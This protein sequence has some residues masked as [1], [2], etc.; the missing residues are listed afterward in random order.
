MKGERHWLSTTEPLVHLA[1]VCPSIYDSLLHTSG[2]R[3]EDLFKSANKKKELPVAVMFVNGSELNEQ[4]FYR[5]PTKDASI[6]S[7]SGI[8][9]GR[10]R[11]F[12]FLI[13]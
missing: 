1:I 13:G 2:F 10:H 12:L 11:Q 6:S 3:G 4:S 9:H 7:R 5:G 8:K